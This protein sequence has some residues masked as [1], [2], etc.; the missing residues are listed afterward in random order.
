[1]TEGSDGETIV[2]CDYDAAWQDWFAVL[3]ARV[4]PAVRDVALRIDHVG[5]TSVPGLAA[6]PIIDMDVVV[7]DEADV[8]VAIER[9][10]TIGYRWIGDLDIV[11]REAFHPPDGGARPEHHLYLVVE[12]NR[13]HQDHWLL[14][15]LLRADPAARARYGDLKRANARV[16]AG[17]L[18]RYTALKAAF[19]AE[20]LTRA[21]IERGLDPVT[22]W[23]PLDDPGARST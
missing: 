19:V 8:P 22:Y 1:M 7:A 6:K 15:D 14:R 5:S 3:Q 16:A 18:G 21:R 9:L 23:A 13:A 17:D 2:V 4:W 11:G 10:D 12:N 20:L